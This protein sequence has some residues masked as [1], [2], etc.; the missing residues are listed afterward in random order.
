VKPLDP[1]ARVEAEDLNATDVPEGPHA[2]KATTAFSIS[3]G[4]NSVSIEQI[5]DAMANFKQSY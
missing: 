5:T 1:Y 3:T 2:M 4:F